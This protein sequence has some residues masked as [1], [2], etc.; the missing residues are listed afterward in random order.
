MCA[1]RSPR[2]AAAGL[3]LRAASRERR[4]GSQGPISGFPF[5]NGFHCTVV[6]GCGRY[7]V[8]WHHAAAS[9]Q[10]PR[11]LPLAA[12]ASFCVPIGGHL[13]CRRTLKPPLRSLPSP[14]CRCRTHRCRVRRRHRRHSGSRPTDALPV[15]RCRRRQHHPRWQLLAALVVTAAGGRQIVAHPARY[16]TGTASRCSC[17]SHT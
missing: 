16:T 3:Y 6:N 8:V 1:C 10:L 9:S 11:A 2:R 12:V 7:S 17:V 4:R 14:R 13:W 5:S 15:P